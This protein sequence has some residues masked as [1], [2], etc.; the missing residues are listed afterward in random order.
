MQVVAVVQAR[1]ASTRLPGKVMMDVAGIPLVA[2]TL[3]R[4]AACERVDKI[5]LAT[6]DRAL[7]DPLVR[8]AEDEGVAWHRGSETD[9]LRRVRDAA[10]AA[11][12]DVVVRITGDCP[13]LDPGVVDDVVCELQTSGCDYASN[14]VR[15][16]YPKGL[17]AEALWWDTMERLDRLATSDAAREHVTWFAY[18][19]RPDLFLLRSV[20]LDEDH[21]QINWSVDTE[22]D[23]RGVSALT[24]P[25]E[26]GQ[27]P[28][29][30]NDLLR[31]AGR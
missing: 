20:E 26:R 31:R 17:D 16:S 14:V 22:E 23:L 7:D 18:Q 27:R 9:V 28:A 29:P 24:Q 1:M 3:R 4:L 5:V 19:E 10:G 30:W 15:R 2:H 11:S 21:S 8:L 25:L 6:T 12:A 13:L